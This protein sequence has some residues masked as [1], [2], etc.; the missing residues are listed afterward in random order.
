MT[1]GTSRGFD[2]YSLGVNPSNIV[3]MSATI[4]SDRSPRGKIIVDELEHLGT[5]PTSAPNDV[6]FIRGKGG[7]LWFG[8]GCQG[9]PEGCFIPASNQSP[10]ALFYRIFPGTRIGGAGVSVPSLYRSDAFNYDGKDRFFSYKST[11]GTPNRGWLRVEYT[12]TKSTVKDPYVF[13]S[14]AISLDSWPMNSRAGHSVKFTDLGVAANRIARLTTTIRSN[15]VTFP[16]GRSYYEFSNFFRPKSGSGGIEG[17]AERKGG[18]LTYVDEDLNLIVLKHGA[19]SLEFSPT[20]YYRDFFS[21]TANRGYVLADY[22]AG[23]CAQGGNGFLLKAIPSPRTEQCDGSGNLVLEAAGQ[24]IWG[25]AD[26]FTYVYKSL[27][28]AGAPPPANQTFIAKIVS[29]GNSNPWAKTGLMIRVGLG[30]NSAHVSMMV[31]PSNGVQFTRR[32]DGTNM[33][34]AHVWQTDASVKAP[35]FLR[36]IKS[37]NTFTGSYSTDGVTWKAPSGSQSTTVTTGNPYYVGIAG[38][39]MSPNMNNSTVSNLNF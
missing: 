27:G 14:R 18:G 31:T 4:Y 36:I 33:S 34:T 3:D 20:Y 8:Y 23:S 35:V 12:G 25:T 26:E 39:S 38:S 17:D 10:N 2:R 5:K 28:T 37:G 15:Q 9:G 29:Q 1:D 13:K 16:N 22:L 21:G 11:S 24:D 32:P 19:Y 6:P 7:Q 30:A